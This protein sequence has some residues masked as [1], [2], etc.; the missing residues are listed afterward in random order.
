MKIESKHPDKFIYIF[1]WI[2][3]I[4]MLVF[5]CFGSWI[6]DEKISLSE[7]MM[8]FIIWGVP[9]NYQFIKIEIFY[10]RTIEFDEN[11]CTVKF[12]FLKKKYTWA[13]LKIKRLEKYEIQY[14][15]PDN[16]QNKGTRVAVFSPHKFLKPKSLLPVAYFFIPFINPYTYIFINLTGNDNNPVPKGYY[17]YDENEFMQKMKEWNVE[18][19][20][21]TIKKGWKPPAL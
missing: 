16:S 8:F 7:R 17:E 18:F 12:L 4:I 21:R 19:E 11:G 6:N 2:F 14:P 3:S 20:E 13:K 5:I 9:I 15:I 1:A 10:F